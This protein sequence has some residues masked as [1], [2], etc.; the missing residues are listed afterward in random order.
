MGTLLQIAIAVIGLVVYYWR[1]RWLFLYWMITLPFLKPIV[2]LMAGVSDVEETS[3]LVHG[4]YFLY[5]YIWVVLDSLL[6]RRRRVPQMRTVYVMM[7]VLVFYFLF[8]A[9]ATGGGLST[10]YYNIKS[11]LEIALP[12]IVFSIN[13]KTQPDIKELYGL[14]WILFIVETLA[15]IMNI[16]GFR[17]YAATYQHMIFYNETMM[18]GTFPFSQLFGNYITTVFLFICIDFFSTKRIS[19]W[20]FLILSIMALFCILS[21]GSRMCI[22]LAMIGIF[23]S[24]FIYQRHH[25][26]LLATLIIGGYFGL[27]AIANFKGGDISSNEGINRIVNGLATFSQSQRG[28]VEDNS[29][30]SLS[31]K[32]LESYFFKSP[33]IGNGISAE[34]NDYSLDIDS[35]TNDLRHMKADAR[36]AFTLIDIGLIGLIIY[37]LYFHQIFKYMGLKMRPYYRKSLYVSFVFFLLFSITESGFWDAYAY[38][39]VYIYYFALIKSFFQETI[40]RSKGV[41]RF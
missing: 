33:L 16:M 8:H 29:T 35:R 32:L 37:L 41:S 1:P 22:S 12:L 25:R 4:G 38:P 40:I 24:V 18:T 27:T 3:S 39:I 7:A 15:V 9:F 2:C 17:F 6:L 20:A 34:G 11:V 5:L 26:F 10:A 30:V 36:L 28:E 14:I 31:S 13:P 19:S 21:A 23:L